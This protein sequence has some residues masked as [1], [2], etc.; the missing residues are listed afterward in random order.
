MEIRILGTGCPNCL[1]LERVAREAVQEAGVQAEFVKV[2]DIAEIMTYPILGTPGLV[3]NGR[4]KASGRIPRK[5]EI[6]AWLKD[7]QG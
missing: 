2:T 4:V 1:R 6:I 5:E 7:A 3:I